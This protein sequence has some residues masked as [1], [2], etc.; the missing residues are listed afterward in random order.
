MK[1]RTLIS[2]FILWLACAAIA[3]AQESRATLIGRATDTSGAVI[4]D[5]TVRAVNTATN[6]E[7]ASTTNE[8]GNYE[9]PYLLSG[10]YT[11]VVEMAGFK[12]SV[13]DGIQLRVGDRV[14]LDFTMTVGDVAE[15]V[16]VTAETPLLEAAK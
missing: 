15:S 5:A 9:I 8:S 11:V 16:T 12:K 4:A 10:V 13:R 6:A 3:A 1:P 2:T 7:V 14:T